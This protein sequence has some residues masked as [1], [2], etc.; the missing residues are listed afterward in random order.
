M[1]FIF[2]KKLNIVISI[3]IGI[4]YPKIGCLF[5]AAELVRTFNVIGK[6]DKQIDKGA[7]KAYLQ[8]EDHLKY[9]SAKELITKINETLVK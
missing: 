5:L 8:S 9:L 1:F 4:V 3:A 7:I 6:I 2:T